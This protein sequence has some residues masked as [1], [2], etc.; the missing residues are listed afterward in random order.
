MAID[1]LAYV[2]EPE[3]AGVDRAT[4]EAQVV[5][6]AKPALPDVATKADLALLEAK[7][8]AKLAKFAN[9]LTWRMI[10]IVALMN[11]IPFALLRLVH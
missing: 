11:G 2:K 6:L 5:A 10:G 3:A 7:F 1:T 8:D 9:D 4:A